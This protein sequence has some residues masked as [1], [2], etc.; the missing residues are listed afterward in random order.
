MKIRFTATA[1]L[2]ASLLLTLRAAEPRTFEGVKLDELKETQQLKDMPEIYE[3]DPANGRRFQLRRAVV[4]LPL[5]EAWITF[6]PERRVSYVNKVPGEI[7]AS[8]F[9][10]IAGDAFEI[11]KLEEKFIAK[12]RAADYAGDVPYRIELML[13]TGDATLRARVLRLMTAGLAADLA[14]ETRANHL[15]K[16]KELAA[17]L[18]GDEAAP[19][20][21]AIVQTEKRIDELTDTLPDSDYSPGNDELARQGKLPDGMKPTVAVPDSAWGQ[22]VNGLRAA[23]VFSTT[24]ATLGDEITVWLLVENSG[25]KEIRFGCSDVVQSA[26]A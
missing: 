17:K 19:L 23:A 16:F 5:G 12:L 9:G 20:L 7:A 6:N 22:P 18:T 14:A 2:A 11:F 15:P 8:Y 25:D 13:R 24:N 10:P 21:A 1:I 26:R 4:Q 3:R